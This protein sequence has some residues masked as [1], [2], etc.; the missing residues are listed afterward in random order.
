MRKKKLIK[1]EVVFSKDDE[2]NFE[3]WYDFL[4][5]VEFKLKIIKLKKEKMVVKMETYN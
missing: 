2:E 4:W 5:D 1:K 3:F